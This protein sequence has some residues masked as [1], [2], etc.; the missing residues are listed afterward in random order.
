MREPHKRS[1]WGVQWEMSIRW[2]GFKSEEERN[3]EKG[4]NRTNSACGSCTSVREVG[5]TW[6]MHCKIIFN[7]YFCP[8]SCKKKKKKGKTFLKQGI[9]TSEANLQI[10]LRLGL[11]INLTAYFRICLKQEWPMGLHSGYILWNKI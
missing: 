7:H 9:F 5:Y 3:D 6:D 2:V 4:W 11:S 1:L 10:I 8:V